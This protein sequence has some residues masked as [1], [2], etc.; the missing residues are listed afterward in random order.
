MPF[1]QDIEISEDEEQMAIDM[2]LEDYI[3]E[4]DN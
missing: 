4:E 3:Y 1:I 2:G